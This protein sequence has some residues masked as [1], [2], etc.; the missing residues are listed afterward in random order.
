MLILKKIE[1]KGVKFKGTF[2]EGIEENKS[3]IGYDKYVRVATDTENVINVEPSWYVTNDI[4]QNDEN[5]TGYVAFE[6]E[7]QFPTAP[8][9]IADIDDPKNPQHDILLVMPQSLT[10]DATLY[11]TYNVGGVD[12][13]KSFALSSANIL[14]SNGKETNSTLSQWL[15]GN[16]YTY[17]LHYSKEASNADRIYFAPS[18]D[19]WKDAGIAVIELL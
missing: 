6:G 7:L 2:T 9:Y 14:D 5:V 8:E 18:T 15:M 16:R 10:D 4:I 1:I 3:G 17:R 12:I 11:V 19:G 13:P